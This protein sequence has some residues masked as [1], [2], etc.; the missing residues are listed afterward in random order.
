MTIEQAITP[1]RAA[2]LS[3]NPKEAIVCLRHGE[4]EAG[5]SPTFLCGWFVADSAVSTAIPRP[6]QLD[7]RRT[8][9][10]RSECIPKIGLGIYPVVTSET[11]NE[12]QATLH[13]RWGYAYIQVG[14]ERFPHRKR[15]IT[16]IFTKLS[17]CSFS[18]SNAH[19]IGSFAASLNRLQPGAVV[20]KVIIFIASQRLSVVITSCRF[21]AITL[22]RSGRSLCI[23][24]RGL[25]GVTSERLPV[26]LR[27]LSPNDSGMTEAGDV[28]HVIRSTGKSGAVRTTTARAVVF[29][30]PE[31]RQSA[32]RSSSNSCTN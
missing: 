28:R 24:S 7:T 1:M 21:R 20:S 9:W 29:R 6:V 15:F 14:C 23:D 10:A 3:E 26:L 32:F 19:T 2:M 31:F 8:F 12:L 16:R 25:P 11:Q 5:R 17:R 4:I 27:E 30:T 13:K 18:S 22:Y